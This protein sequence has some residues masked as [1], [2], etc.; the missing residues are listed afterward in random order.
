[1]IL[2]VD[3]GTSSVRAAAVDAEAG[4]LVDVT[5]RPFAP[6]TPAP[7]LVEFDPADLASTLLDGSLVM[8]IEEICDAIR[9]LAARAHVIAEGAGG[10]AVAGALELACREAAAENEGLPAARRIV[11][12][13]SGGNID[14]HVLRAILAGDN[15]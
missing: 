6:S 9:L 4:E 2:V 11:A 15:P 3:I 1:M 14:T 12:V 7:G 5:Q 8:S 13:V 10:S